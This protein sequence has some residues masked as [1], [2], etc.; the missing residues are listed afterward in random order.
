MSSQ[1]IQ[2]GSLVFEYGNDVYKGG[3]FFFV[4]D[5]ALRRVVEQGSTALGLTEI[6]LAERMKRFKAPERQI[7]NVLLK[8]PI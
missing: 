1:K 3:Y 6:E 7:M 2:V 4:R 5:L 8:R